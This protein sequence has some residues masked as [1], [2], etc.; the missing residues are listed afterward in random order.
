MTWIDWALLCVFIGGFLLFLYGA[1][2]YSIVAGYSGV[3]LFL[4]AIATYLIIFT[5]KELKK[6]AAPTPTYEGTI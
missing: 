3:C 2:Y 1:N 6:P 4:G 5:Y